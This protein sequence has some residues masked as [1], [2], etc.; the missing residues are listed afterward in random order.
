MIQGINIEGN[1]KARVSG[2]DHNSIIKYL[3]HKNTFVGANNSGKSRLLR[4]IFSNQEVNFLLKPD[5]EKL[6]GIQKVYAPIIKILDS[7]ETS[8]ITYNYRNT[9][10]GFI[11]NID[12]A[13]PKVVGN[14][15]NLLFYLSTLEE[16][17][18]KLANPGHGNHLKQR[19]STTKSHIV[20]FKKKFDELK[21]ASKTV[22]KIYIPILRGL[23]PINLSEEKFNSKNLYLSRTK[24][25]YFEDDITK[26]QI[27]TG[28][29]I[30]EE[31]KKLLLGNENE[32]NEIIAFEKFL[33][34]NVFKEKINLIPKYND[35]VLHIKLGQVKQF[36]IY[37][38]GDG[39]QTLITILF[40]IFINWDYVSAIFVEEPETHLHPKWQ[41]LLT[42]SLDE[43]KNYTYF[44]ST[45]SSA[46]I[47]SENNSIFIVSQEDSKTHI[48]Y[49][50]IKVEKVDILRDLGYK[51]NDLFQTNYILWVE[52]PS[53]KSYMNYLISKYA[54]NLKEDED[55]S[56]M[57]YGGSSYQHFLMN[58]GNFNLDFIQSLNQNYGIILDSDRSKRHERYSKKKREIE[59]L[60]KENKAFCWLTQ[61]REIENYI[62]VDKFEEAIKKTHKLKNINID[63]SEFGDRCSIEDLDAKPSFKSTIKL[64]QK[65]F[66]QVQKNK[67]GTTTGINAK[68]LRKEIE[69]AIIA[70][71]KMTQKIDKV[72]V[73]EEVVSQ[74]FEVQNDEL[75]KVMNKLVEEIKKAND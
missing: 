52:G 42:R 66:T 44:F 63:K 19:L 4:D 5:E 35:D 25:D 61:L 14:I 30:Y 34:K 60:F 11:K 12:I 21:A 38:L 3:S 53:D 47:N 67:D 33:Q 70:T 69:N 10:N 2:L 9:V 65:I 41:R 26:G 7:L 72:R 50:D 57:F 56:I 71:K 62:P 40:P 27:F 1:L 22:N 58:K 24:H 17:E 16:K 45:H 31:I 46:F 36:P 48:H 64:S 18:F 43:F 54:P 37:Q 68:D 59:K 75:N 51:P 49:S 74:G 20:Q 73:A 55:Y 39:L 15:S 32:R 8:K 29:S 28:L 23:R 13:N 6:D